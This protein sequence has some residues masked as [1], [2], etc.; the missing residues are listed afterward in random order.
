MVWK[1]ETRSENET[2]VLAAKLASKLSGGE[3]ICLLGELGSGKTTFVQ[4]LAEGLGIVAPIVSP[5]FTLVR[6]Y[7]GRLMLFHVDAYRLSGLSAEDVQQQIGLLD[8]MERKG[9]V[10]IEWADMIAHIL[11]TERLE[12][13]FEHTENGRLINFMPIGEFYESLVERIASERR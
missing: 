8:Y 12:I 6:E 5:T 4:G 13:I 11:P 1:V 2:K 9:V 10:V 7:F 3:V